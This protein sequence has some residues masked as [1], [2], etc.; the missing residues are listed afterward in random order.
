MYFFDLVLAKPSSAILDMAPQKPP[1]GDRAEHDTNG[2]V[3][4]AV[5]FTIL[6][7]TCVAL[8][9]WARKIGKVS[10]GVDDSLM[11]P[12]LILCLAVNALCLCEQEPWSLRRK[13]FSRANDGQKV[14]LGMVELVITRITWPPRIP[15]SSWCGPNM[16]LPY[17]RYTLLP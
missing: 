4:V 10:F 8:R 17:P 9:F 13:S 5:I 1:S 16:R 6:E 14:T 7:V 15:R 3:P 11:V 12:S 2:V